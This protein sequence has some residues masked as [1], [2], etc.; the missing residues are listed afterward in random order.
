ML[1]RHDPFSEF[2]RILNNV[3]EIDYAN[4]DEAGKRYIASELKKMREEMYSFGEEMKKKIKE[5]DD[6]RKT[7]DGE[8]A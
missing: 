2:I 1:E 3:M 7:V 6:G 8:P 5:A 4:A